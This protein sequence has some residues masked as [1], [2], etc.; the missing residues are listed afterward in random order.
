M[1]QRMSYEAIR[2]VLLR[3]W[4]PI[5]IRDQQAARDEYDTYARRLHS[6][7]ASRPTVSE[8]EAYLVETEQE[9]MGL[10]AD[11]ERARHVAEILLNHTA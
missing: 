3:E 6:F 11:N 10:A 1:K 8:V 7:L 4:D 2:D 9:L 5:D